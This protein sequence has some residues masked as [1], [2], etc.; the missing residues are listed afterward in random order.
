[1]AQYKK[2]NLVYVTVQYKKINGF[3]LIMCKKLKFETVIK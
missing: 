2:V 1:M 3:K